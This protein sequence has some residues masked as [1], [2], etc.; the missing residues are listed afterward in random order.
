MIFS[1]NTDGSILKIS[2]LIS[3]HFSIVSN[4]VFTLPEFKSQMQLFCYLIIS[5]F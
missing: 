5:S 3:N 4:G 2:G 1:L